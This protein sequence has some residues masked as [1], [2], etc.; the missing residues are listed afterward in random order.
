M[1]GWTVDGIAL[2]PDPPSRGEVKFAA[3]TV[4]LA[5]SLNATA[6][7]VFRGCKTR[8]RSIQDNHE[9]HEIHEKN[10]LF[11]PR[12]RRKKGA[13]VGPPLPRWTVNMIALS[14]FPG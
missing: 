9:I 1:P 13:R 4:P 7:R 10:M 12:C 14:D 3:G 5:L 11:V 6:F 8:G 2:L